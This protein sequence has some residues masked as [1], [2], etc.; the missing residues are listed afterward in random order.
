M[1][2]CII[3]ETTNRQRSVQL[4]DYCHFAILDYVTNKTP[5]TR[6]LGG[7]CQLF[8]FFKQLAGT[9][10]LFC[11]YEKHRTFYLSS[12]AQSNLIIK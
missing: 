8:F 3:T 11:R 9:P 6:F 7:G 4:K 5:Y 2:A 10:L 1:P 12:H